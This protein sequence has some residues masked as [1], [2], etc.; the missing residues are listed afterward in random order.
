MQKAAEE[1]FRTLGYWGSAIVLD[2][3]SGLVSVDA[4]RLQQVVWNLLSNAIK[5]TPP[6]GRVTVRAARGETRVTVTTTD[7]G[8]AIQWA[9]A[10]ALA[11]TVMNPVL[12]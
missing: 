12:V 3:R 11:P 6:G 4:A 2:P 8:A 5:F 10:N 7:T 9:M 1:G